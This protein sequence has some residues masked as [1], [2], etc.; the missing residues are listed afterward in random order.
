[1]TQAQSKGRWLMKNALYNLFIHEVTILCYRNC[2]QYFPAGSRILDV[3]IGNGAMIRAFHA[4]IRSRNLSI[5]GIDINRCYLDH[6][7]SQIKKWG[8]EQNITVLH[9]PVETYEPP[10]KPWFDFIL[11]SMSFM[12]LEDPCMV[13]DRIRSWLKPGGRIL[14]FQTMFRDHSFIMELIKPR[15]KYL[16]S[17]DFGRVIY[18]EEF[19]RLLRGKGIEVV[20]DILISRKWFAGEYRLIISTPHECRMRSY[21]F[22][23]RTAQQGIPSSRPRP[24]RKVK[25]G[26]TLS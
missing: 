15:L 6:C 8:L 21:A 20:E 16:T 14:F 2:I 5:T 13:L 22:R 25:A 18:E 11:F 19:F 24:L 26:S 7:S 10:V 4:L 12:L 3:G 23:T 9:E 17:I 1:M